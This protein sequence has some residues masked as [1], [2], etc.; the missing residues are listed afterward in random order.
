[1]GAAVVSLFEGQAIG[2]TQDQFYH[3][4]AMRSL[5]ASGRPLV[6]DPL[7]GSAVRVL[8]P[9][10]GAWHTLGASLAMITRADLVDLAPGLTAAAAAAFAFCLWSMFRRVSGDRL[11]PAIVTLAFLGIVQAFDFRFIGYPKEFSWGLALFALVLLARAA[12]SSDPALP[13]AAAGVGFAALATHLGSGELYL[14]AAA[15]LMLYLGAMVLITRGG[16][17]PYQPKGLVRVGAAVGVAVLLALPVLLMRVSALSGSDS[18]SAHQPVEGLSLSSFLLLGHR[19]VV[20]R[21]NLLDGVWLIATVPLIVIAALAAARTRDPRAFLALALGS[22]RVLLVF[23]PI[24]LSSLVRFSPY[25]TERLAALLVFAPFCLVGWGLSTGR[26]TRNVWLLVACS[27]ALLVAA[28]VGAGELR[29]IWS[30][31]IQ[32]PSTFAYSKAA[33]L[34]TS[35]GDGELPRLRAVLGPGRPVVAA[36]PNTSLQLAGIANVRI[37]AVPQ[38]NTPAYFEENEGADVKREDMYRLVDEQTPEADRR[39]IARLY[40]AKFVVIDV[41]HV[42]ALAPAV[43]EMM[44]DPSFRLMHVSNGLFV[45]AVV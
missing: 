16:E 33:D 42:P 29:E 24:A 11:V 1:L 3:L 20:A 19:F 25:M 10:S 40:G 31:S 21:P 27:A 4:A 39:T 15:V 12:T 7:F 43:N 6:T 45:F 26:R 17:K 30:P 8:D 5:L 41:L 22:L 14:I 23:D 28:L 32:D 18:V 36:F 44:Q 13:V 35:W 37:V 34:R 9:S 2:G 38:D